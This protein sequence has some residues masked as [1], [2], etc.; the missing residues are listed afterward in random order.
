MYSHVCCHCVLA[1][2]KTAFVCG[3]PGVNSPHHIRL[4]NKPSAQASATNDNARDSGP[5][6]A[7]TAVVHRRSLPRF[8]FPH[9]TTP[10]A[11]VLVA[12]DVCIRQGL[13]AGQ[14]LM[15]DLTCL[16]THYIRHFDTCDCNMHNQNGNGSCDIRLS[17]A[18][19]ATQNAPAKEGWLANLSDLRQR[20]FGVAAMLDIGRISVRGS[21]RAHSSIYRRHQR[22]A[23][24]KPA[25][26]VW[27]RNIGRADSGWRWRTVLADSDG[28]AIA[29]QDTIHL[30]DHGT[31]PQCMFNAKPEIMAMR[32]LLCSPASILR[33]DITSSIVKLA[34]IYAA[35]L[36]H[37]SVE[38]HKTWRLRSMPASF[39]YGDALNVASIVR[40][41]LQPPM[42]ARLQH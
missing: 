4:A 27:Y 30:P 3:L 19:S 7:S 2:N 18:Q 15:S 22:S 6:T 26:Y 28:L 14:V 16:T 34:A 37:L 41:L 29:P 12:T 31:S 9:G 10:S 21:I 1:S 33:D 35:C 38:C 39:L 25:L 36:L 24:T 13:G 20:I 11:T 23:R 32:S 8:N 40:L 5:T 17:R 42:L